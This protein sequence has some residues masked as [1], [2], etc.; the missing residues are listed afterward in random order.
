VFTADGRGAV[1]RAEPGGVI[2]RSYFD[3]TLIQ[4]LPGA[5][6]LNGV[7]WVRVIAPDGVEGWMVQSVLATATPSPNW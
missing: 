5:I 2:V 6:E 3:G 1:V 7:T 4:V